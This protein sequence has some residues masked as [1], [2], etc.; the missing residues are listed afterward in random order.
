M[1]QC[2]APNRVLAQDPVLPEWNP[3]LDPAIAQLVRVMETA[4]DEGARVEARANLLLLHDAKLFMAFHLWI[5]MLTGD[6]RVQQLGEQRRW[7]KQREEAV[8]SVGAPMASGN[9]AIE[10]TVERTT[11]IE[12]RAVDR[13]ERWLNERRRRK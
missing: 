11:V 12:Q 4:A 2:L 10:M 9:H 3:D 5:D 7:L 1:T 8:D 13:Y 6:E